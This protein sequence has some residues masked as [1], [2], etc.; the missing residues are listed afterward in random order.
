VLLGSWGGAALVTVS[1]QS[2]LDVTMTV[3]GVPDETDGTDK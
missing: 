2:G 3:A 1:E